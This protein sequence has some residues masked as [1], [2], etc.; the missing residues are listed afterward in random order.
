VTGGIAA[1]MVAFGSA[2][3]CTCVA[4][5]TSTST[6]T[7]MSQLITI[8]LLLRVLVGWAQAQ[9][10]CMCGDKSG[11][12]SGFRESGGCGGERPMCCPVLA[13]ARTSTTACGHAAGCFL[14]INSTVT[15]P[16]A[17]RTAGCVNLVNSTSVP[18]ATNCSDC[19]AAVAEW[20]ACSSTCN[21]DGLQTRTRQVISA[22]VGFGSCNIS[23]SESRSCNVA[24][25]CIGST[26]ASSAV[27][28]ATAVVATTRASSS[29]ATSDV[30]GALSS[31]S[32]ST[33]PLDGLPE[34]R[35]TDSSAAA[36]GAAADGGVP[37]VTPADGTALT[38]TAD[39]GRR[40][41]LA[42]V[43]SG[44]RRCVSRVEAQ[45]CNNCT[46]AVETAARNERE[47]DSSVRAVCV[48][49]R[50]SSRSLRRS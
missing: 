28:T 3:A 48:C 37:P 29:S 17:L 15:T 46:R 14:Q 24:V 21:N 16:V 42:G 1:T 40:C 30:V 31:S 50:R 47:Q 2:C 32:S 39:C 13:C 49:E 11:C 45:N 10:G 38:P 12:N 20:S 4:R 23:L 27:T 6:D 34:F 33:P 8:V 9:T 5:H 26:A 25:P 44:A 19:V 18:C 7:N 22:A 43:R 35:T 41:V 36:D